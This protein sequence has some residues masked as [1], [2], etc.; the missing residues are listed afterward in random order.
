MSNEKRTPEK[1]D[2]ASLLLKIMERAIRSENL[3]GLTDGILLE[4]AELVDSESVLLYVRPLSH[5]SEWGFP[6]QDI[7]GLQALCSEKYD[8][9]S[10]QADLDLIVVPPSEYSKPDTRLVLHSLRGKGAY[11]GFI[12]LMHTA[13]GIN[14][15]EE[16]WQGFLSLLCKLVEDLIDRTQFE[17]QMRHLN[18]YMT[19]SSLMAQPLGLPEMLEAALYCCMEAS[20]A[21]AASVL[22]VGE[23]KNNFHFYQVEGPSKPDLVAVTFPIGEGIAG[24]VL[25][26]QE[27]EIINDVQS[28]ARFYGQIDTQSG[29]KTEKM[30]AI[31]LTAGEEQIGV[32][33]VINKADDSDFTEDERH[34]LM[35]I[36]EEIA[37][38]IRNA[39][40]FEYVVD[41]YCLQR[42]GM[43]TC[44]GCKRPL[45]T[46]TPCVKYREDSG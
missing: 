21:E 33:E 12:G 27:S 24:S 42:Q 19:V 45:G 17:D 34:S 6:D 43:N 31:P 46:W 44:R 39:R 11:P 38:A 25:K 23:N 8:Q 14:I 4:I 40:I 41:S 30:I 35:M 3:S 1:D 15:S 10:D 9:F 5:F 20:S 26:S 7:P 18:T 37:F 13:T 2:Q 36:A 32:L 29:I 22:L 28:D 16:K